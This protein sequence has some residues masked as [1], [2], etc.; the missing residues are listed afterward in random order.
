MRKIVINIYICTTSLSKSC[1]F[2]HHHH[3]KIDFTC[4]GVQQTQT[5]THT[6]TK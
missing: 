3:Q 2:E 4:H 6:Y 1:D 5:H